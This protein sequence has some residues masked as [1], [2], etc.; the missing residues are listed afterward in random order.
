MTAKEK[1][2]QTFWFKLVAVQDEKRISAQ[3]PTAGIQ[4]ETDVPYLKDGNPM[5]LLDV[6]RP[7]QAEG[8]LPVIIDV[9]GGGWM[10]GTKQINRNYCL[11]LAGRGFVVFNLNYRLLPEVRF[12]GQMQDLFAALR[13]IGE[14][15]AAY[16]G[17]RENIF[18]TGDS[19]GGM[20]VTLASV[21]NGNRAYEAD[22]GVCSTGVAFRAV[23]ATSPAVDITSGIMRQMLPV[24]L[25]P[26]YKN[27][28]LYPYMDFEKVYHGQQIPPF[29][30]VTSGGD[31]IRQQAR[32]LHRVLRSH[33]AEHRFHDWTGESRKSLPHVFSVL[34]P[35]QKEGAAT[36]DEMVCYFRQFLKEPAQ[37]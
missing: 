15:C 30:V 19:A 3:V 12:D 8:M 13:W 18:L 16:G 35:L 34:E 36:I 1:L 14:H 23:G 2:L 31:F 26:D 10:Y 33:N 5:H 6:Y 4:K 24:L 25:G 37:V 11:A 28:K 29:Y 9:H 32:K 17:D 21:V 27:S 20:M 7:E 22:F